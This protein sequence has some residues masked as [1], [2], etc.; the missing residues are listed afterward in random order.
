[1][2][3]K[4]SGEDL[5]GKLS[6]LS[7]CKKPDI[8]YVKIF[9]IRNPAKSHSL[10]KKCQVLKESSSFILCLQDAKISKLTNVH[11]SLLDK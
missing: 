9:S 6:K 11:L 1:M 4:V 8:F 2:K 5:E 3:S 7:M 10:I